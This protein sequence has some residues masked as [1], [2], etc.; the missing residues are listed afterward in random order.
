MSPRGETRREMRARQ[1]SAGKLGVTCLSI[2]DSRQ[3]TF[4]A[5]KL[6]MTA[7]SETAVEAGPRLMHTAASEPCVGCLTPDLRRCY[8]RQQPLTL[9]PLPPWPCSGLSYVQGRIFSLLSTFCLLLFLL[10]LLLSHFLQETANTYPFSLAHSL[11]GPR[12]RNH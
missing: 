4:V 12:A 1:S 2:T 3:I 8:Q 10:F 7:P 9:R 11:N 5:K 6:A